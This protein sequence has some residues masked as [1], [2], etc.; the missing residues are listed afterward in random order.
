MRMAIGLKSHAKFSIT[1]L[2]ENL[3]TRTCSFCGILAK[4][5][6]MRTAERVCNGCGALNRYCPDLCK[7]VMGQIEDARDSRKD[8]V[9][10]KTE[11]GSGDEEDVR[12]E[13]GWE[14]MLSIPIVGVL[15]CVEAAWLD[16]RGT[17]ET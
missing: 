14:D 12:K 4:F 6:C 10:V 9:P 5:M 13:K 7:L 16:K 3:C 17:G 8:W 11:G 2:Y 1:F 15:G